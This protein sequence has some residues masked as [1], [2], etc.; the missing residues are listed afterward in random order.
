[1]SLA[2]SLT[3]GSAANVEPQFS[4]LIFPYKIDFSKL[5]DKDRNE[6][7][8]RLGIKGTNPTTV[9]VKEDKVVAVQEGYVES[10]KYVDFLIKAKILKEGSKYSKVANLTF[11]NYDKYLDILKK[12]DGKSVVLVSQ[13]GCEYC[14]SAKPILNNISKGYKFKIN[15]L[16]VTD[17][18]NKQ[19][20]EFFEELPKIGYDNEE[21]TENDNFNMPT[22]LII[23]KG[24]VTSYYEGA[25]SLEEYVS[26]FKEKKI[27]NS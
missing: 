17:F 6:I 1:M 13:A 19:L 14:L 12:K 2:I 7:E 25:H 26:Y 21:L 9:V 16:E 20:K 24:H 3:N 22:I 10:N 18:N 27:I 11:I 4:F 15:V 8:D 23:E 5:N